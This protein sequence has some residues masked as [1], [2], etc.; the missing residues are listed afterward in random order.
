V[1]FRRLE[2]SNSQPERVD[3]A[4]NADQDVVQVMLDQKEKYL[5]LERQIIA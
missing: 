3:V 5:Q 1:Y 2:K 4:K